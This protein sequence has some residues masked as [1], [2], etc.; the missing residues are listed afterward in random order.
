MDSSFTDKLKYYV[1]SSKYTSY[2]MAV[3]TSFEVVRLVYRCVL[4]TQNLLINMN[5]HN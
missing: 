2:V 3:A 4:S 5:I 1:H